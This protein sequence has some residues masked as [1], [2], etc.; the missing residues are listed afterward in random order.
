MLN[1]LLAVCLYSQFKC[2]LPTKVGQFSGEQLPSLVSVF[3]IT[4]VQHPD[5]QIV[6]VAAERKE[7]IITYSCMSL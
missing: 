1:K 5:C 7:S 3:I 6:K 4:F 2:R